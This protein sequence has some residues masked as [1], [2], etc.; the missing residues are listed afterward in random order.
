ME[1]AHINTK[2]DE[3]LGVLKQKILRMGEMVINNIES[4]ISSVTNRDVELAEVIIESDHQINELEVDAEEMCLRIIALRQPAG[5]DLRF[6]STAMKIITTLERMGDLA[7]NIGNRS[8][9]LAKEPRMGICFHLPIMTESTEDLV[10][11]A[12][13][14]F[15]NEDVDKALIVCRDDEYV[16]QTYKQLIEELMQMMAEKTIPIPRA[17]K[18]MLVAKYLERIADHA[19]HISE[20]VVFMVVGKVIRHQES[21]MDYLDDQFHK[22]RHGAGE[23][24]PPDTSSGTS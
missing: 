9:E 24:T 15:V 7:V 5:R 17:M 14:A 18:I 20:M 12:L 16:D 13:D 11:R 6:I 2:Y 22:S 23:D 21:T 19:V 1:R 10:R 8:I 3:E 4:A